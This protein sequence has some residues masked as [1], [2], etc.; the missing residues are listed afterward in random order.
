MNAYPHLSGN[1]SKLGKL[2]AGLNLPALITCR[3]DAPCRKTCYACHGRFNMFKNIKEALMN[4]LKAYLDNPEYFFEKIIIE[5]KM[6]GY[7]WFRWHS[8]G[9]IPN[10][11]YLMGMIHVAEKLPDVQFLCFTKKYEI[12]NSYLDLHKEFPKNLHMVFSRWGEYPVPNPYE[13]PEAHIRFKKENG[14][15]NNSVIPADA[16]ICEGGKEV[17]PGHK[18]TCSNCVNVTGNCW[19][20]KS[21]ESVVFG[22]H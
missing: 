22:Q 17:I 9:D 16:H 2:V 5:M 11:D 13:L 20:M 15:E 3:P 12:V 18:Y 10:Y 21:D 4:N 19:K 1:N 6:S 14:I 8:S 7:R